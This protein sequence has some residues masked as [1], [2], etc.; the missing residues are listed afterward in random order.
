MVWSMGHNSTVRATSVGSN[1]TFP[2]VPQLWLSPGWGNLFAALSPGVVLDFP[3][4]GASWRIRK[5][6]NPSTGWI[7]ASSTTQERSPTVLWV[8]DSGQAGA[9]ELLNCSGWWGPDGKRDYKIPAL[10]RRWPGSLK[11]GSSENFELTVPIFFFIFFFNSM[12]FFFQ[13]F[14]RRIMIYC[15]E[16][17]RR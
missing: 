11:C 8:S 4:A 6:A 16:T 1:T 9:P 10:C 12:I 17:W 14:W 2:A 13:D 3:P 15:T 5:R 7:S